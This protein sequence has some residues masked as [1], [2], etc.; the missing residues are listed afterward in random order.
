[1]HCPRKQL[2]LQSLVV[3]SLFLVFC[4]FGQA[5]TLLRA[6]AHGRSFHGS[7]TPSTAGS[8]STVATAPTRRSGAVLRNRALSCTLGEFGH[9]IPPV[10]ILPRPLLVFITPDGFASSSSDR[11][12][13]LNDYVEKAG[14]GGAALIQMRDNISVEANKLVLGPD[15]RF[16]AA[17][18]ESLF[19]VNGEPDFARALKAD[20]VHL[21]EYMM[22]RM[23]GLR[24]DPEWPRVVGCSVHSAESALEAARL[25]ADYVQVRVRHNGKLSK[26]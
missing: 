12:S 20:G 22:D 21:P 11:V 23:V 16:A 5:F 9:T 24:D 7:P 18:G 14:V 19:V 10:P 25:G 26:L 3:V 6:V 13:A 8:T 17:E 2:K 15:I 4:S 1:M